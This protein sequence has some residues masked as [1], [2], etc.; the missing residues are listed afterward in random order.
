[1]KTETR[2]IHRCDH[3]KKVYLQKH[4]A[5]AHEKWCSKNPANK[6]ACFSCQHMEV[7]RMDSE[8]THTG[9]GR[10]SEKS[11]YCKIKNEALHSFKAEKMQHSCLSET[12]RM[13]LQCQFHRYSFEGNMTQ[14]EMDAAA[15]AARKMMEA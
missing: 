12:V 9:F 1:M 13:P 4:S 5:E 8:N 10:F 2:T 3:C 11:F 15:E 6:H 14:Q 7:S